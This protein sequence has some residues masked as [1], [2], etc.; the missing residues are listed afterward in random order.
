[1]SVSRTQVFE[2]LKMFNDGREELGDDQRPVVPE[3]Q[4]QTKTSKQSVKLFETIV[5]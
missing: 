1:M 5:A 3:H 2:W 4:E